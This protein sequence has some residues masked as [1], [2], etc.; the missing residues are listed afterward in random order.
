MMLNIKIVELSETKTFYSHNQALIVLLGIGY[1]LIIMNQFN[2]NSSLSS[3]SYWFDYINTSGMVYTPINHYINEV[4]LFSISSTEF[5][6]DINIFHFDQVINI[7]YVLY[8]YHAI[9]LIIISA[10][11]LLAMVSPIILTHN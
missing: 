2:M 1:Y 7:G 3:L 11:L 4:T 10:I 6:W 8:S 5:N 9:S